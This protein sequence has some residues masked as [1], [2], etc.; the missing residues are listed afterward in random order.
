MA[1]RQQAR[2][3][4]LGGLLIAACALP[5]QAQAPSGDDDGDGVANS[6]DVCPSRHGGGSINGCPRMA[7]SLAGSWVFRRGRLVLKLF[8]VTATPG[9][10]VTITCKGTCPSRSVSV[11]GRGRPQNL[12]GFLNHRLARGTFFELRAT[13]PGSIGTY[14]K[15]AVR[16]TVITF[17]KSCLEPGSSRP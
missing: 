10:S 5:A 17:S 7:A 8:T 13:S 3:A 1:R 6:S 9:A 12:P 14:E 4:W 15:A 11:T 2:L 16:G